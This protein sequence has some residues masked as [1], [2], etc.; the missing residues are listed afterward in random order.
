MFIYY[1][2]E[3][4]R[5]KLCDCVPSVWCLP[6]VWCVSGMG[7]VLCILCLVLCK[8]KYVVWFGG[9]CVQV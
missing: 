9:H 1:G 4:F 5:S 8:S 6:G 7:A 2:V 3:A